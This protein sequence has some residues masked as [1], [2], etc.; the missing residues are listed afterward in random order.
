MFKIASFFIHTG[1]KSLMP[2][3]N[4]TIHNALRQAIP[5]INQS[6]ASGLPCLK[7]ASDIRDPSSRPV[8]DSELD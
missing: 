3:I 7:L 5:S 8:F 6:A 1:L 4:S 2:F